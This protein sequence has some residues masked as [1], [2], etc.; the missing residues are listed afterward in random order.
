MRKQR[1]GGAHHFPQIM[2]LLVLGPHVQLT[3]IFNTLWTWSSLLR[4]QSLG[5]TIFVTFH[6]ISN[7]EDIPPNAEKDGEDQW[8]AVFS[9][10][11]CKTRSSE[12][13]GQEKCLEDCEP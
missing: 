1:W 13:G 3:S 10:P 9:G 7:R 2:Q 12:R 8:G 6:T 4:K 11:G 5:A